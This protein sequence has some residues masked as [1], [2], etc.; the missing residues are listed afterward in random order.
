MD[1][2]QQSR[3]KELIAKGKEQGYLTYSEVNDHMPPG[4]VESDQVE[5]IVS[6]INDMGIT[7]HETA[8]DDDSLLLSESSVS[9][10]DDVAEEAA[11]ALASGDSEFGRTTDPVRMYMREM[12]T[13]ELLTR[14]G[15]IVIAKRIEEGLRE[16]LVALARS[17]SAVASVL[18]AY[19]VYENEEAKLEDFISGFSDYDT[20]E[21]LD[22]GKSASQEGISDNEETDDNVDL[23]DSDDAEDNDNDDDLDTEEP[24]AGLDLEQVQ[25]TIQELK[26]VY[27]K[28]VTE[29]AKGKSSKKLESLVLEMVDAFLRF[30]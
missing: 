18:T 28:V 25:Q 21:N 24:E 14:E 8:P 5:E 22:V 2:E 20:E 11:A 26:V 15:E 23:S 9:A 10:D 12:G 27:D 3:I 6:M 30:K 13:V 7:V 4:I 29:L 19:A 1:K 16:V 17:P